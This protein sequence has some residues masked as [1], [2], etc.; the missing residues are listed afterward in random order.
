MVSWVNPGSELKNKNVGDYVL[1]GVVEAIGEVRKR[2]GR[3][4]RSLLLLPRRD[5]GRDRARLAGG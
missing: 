2:T 3:F 4:A 1:S 5:F